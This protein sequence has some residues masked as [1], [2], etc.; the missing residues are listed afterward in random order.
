MVQPF[1]FNILLLLYQALY[2]H[3]T[4]VLNHKTK[5][6]VTAFVREFFKITIGRKDI[7]IGLNSGLPGH[8]SF[9]RGKKSMAPKTHDIASRPRIGF[10]RLGLMDMKTSP[11]AEG[12]NCLQKRR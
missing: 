4:E 5:R 3:I 6:A 7:Y 9:I 2:F 1:C 8:L 12:R 10:V 11:S